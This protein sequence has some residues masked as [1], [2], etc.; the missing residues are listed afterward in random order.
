VKDWLYRSKLLET[1]NLSDH[2]STPDERRVKR[3]LKALAFDQDTELLTDLNEYMFLKALPQLVEQD[4]FFPYPEPEDVKGEFEI[5]NVIPTGDRFGLNLNQIPRNV[6]IFGSHG[7][8]KTNLIFN[9]IKNLYER[10]MP[11]LIPEVAKVKYRNLIRKFPEIQVLRSQDYLPSPLKGPDNTRPIT[12]LG[13]FIH[14]YTHEM[15]LMQRSQS[16]LVEALDEAYRKFGIY[17]GSREYPTLEDLKLILSEKSN[18]PGCRN[19]DFAL[20]NIQRISMLTILS[21]GRMEHSVGHKIEK[22][23]EVPTVIELAEQNPDLKNFNARMLF[24]YL[25]RHRISK[26]IKGGLEHVLIFDEAKTVFDANLE[27]NFYMGICPIDLLVSYAREYGQGHILADQ[28]GTKLTNSVKANSNCKFSFLVS[29]KE[30]DEVSRMFCLDYKKREAFLQLPPWV[31]LVKMDERY[32]AP[33]LVKVDHFPAED[34]VS[35]EEV[36]DHSRKFVEYLNRDVRPRSTILIQMAEKKKRL[37]SKGAENFLR[38]IAKEPYLSIS[39]RRDKQG[40]TNYM[41]NKDV[42]ELEVKGFVT[43]KRIYTGKQGHP[44]IITEPTAKGWEYL[45]SLGIKP[46]KQGKGGLVHRFWQEKAKE[47]WAS[48]GNKVMVEPNVAGANTD[49]LVMNQDGRRIAIEIALSQENQLNNVLRDLKYFDSVVVASETKSLMMRIE[50]EAQ[51]TLGQEHGKRV[52]FCL[53]GDFLS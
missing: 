32:P 35:D 11:F 26:G 4:P 14:F 47:Y 5:G 30:I 3:L 50:S 19:D 38:N 7:T 46:N 37:L 10:G 27:R 24:H 48:R 13:D 33:F 29:G 31:S 34:E 22:L 8:G 44:I 2:I 49:V 23:L 21:E 43:K 17:K 41:A 42:K 39:Q 40:L 25:L 53:L 12:W 28:E 16:Y 51:K 20:R 15:G 45:R 1:I 52:S 6:L 9:F 18:R 36:E